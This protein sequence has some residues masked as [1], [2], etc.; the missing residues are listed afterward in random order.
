MYKTRGYPI[1][2]ELRRANRAQRNPHR[3]HTLRTLA[4]RSKVT[5]SVTRDWIRVIYARIAQ[6]LSRHQ[7]V[8]ERLGAAPAPRP[9]T[10]GSGTTEVVQ[11]NA[12]GRLARRRLV[13]ARSFGCG[14]PDRGVFLA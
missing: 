3:F 5:S 11:V 9:P 8:E 1:D 14:C 7:H 13:S 4:A 6:V 12:L 2:L 10:I